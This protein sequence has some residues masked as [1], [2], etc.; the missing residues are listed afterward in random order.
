MAMVNNIFTVIFGKESNVSRGHSWR[1]W[2]LRTMI[3]IV[4][5]F[6]PIVVAMWISN[7]AYILQYAGL[8]GIFICFFFPIVLQLCSQRV[9]CEAF[10]RLVDLKDAEG[11]SRDK[12][13]DSVTYE[14][15]NGELI[16][17][18]DCHS[19][20]SLIMS[21][22][23]SVLVE[24]SLPLLSAKNT[25]TWSRWTCPTPYSTVF[26]HPVCVVGIGLLAIGFFLASVASIFVSPL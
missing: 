10:Q 2:I 14:S 24:E 23:Q 3:R 22:T 9:C 21:C 26:S 19:K 7:L 8:I 5:A 4:C 1:H 12:G 20:S 11:A 16:S 6:L 18:V 13:Y 17:V 25:T 15:S